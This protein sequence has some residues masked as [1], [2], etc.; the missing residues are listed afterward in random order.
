MARN[1]VKVVGI[2]EKSGII[3]VTFLCS[4]KSEKSILKTKAIKDYPELYFA[5]LHKHAAF[6]IES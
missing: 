2:T 5:Y 6:R 3:Y 1:F 4:D